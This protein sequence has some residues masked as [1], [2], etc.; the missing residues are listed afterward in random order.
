MDALCV[1]CMM[2]PPPPPSYHYNNLAHPESNWPQQLEL[3]WCCS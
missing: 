2:L 3:P 1:K